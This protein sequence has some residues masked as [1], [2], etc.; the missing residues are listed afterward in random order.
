MDRLYQS[1]VDDLI[2]NG[3]VESMSKYVQHG[4][5]STLEHCEHVSYLSYKICKSLRLDYRAAARGGLLHDYFLYDWHINPPTEW[6]GY[7]HPAIALK[8]AQRD[9]SLNKKECDI[10]KKHMWPLTLTKVPKYP[11][12]F[13]VSF[14]DKYATVYEV[15]MSKKTKSLSDHLVKPV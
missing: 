13:I 11:E 9:F 12:S 3:K 15:I 7:R 2:N 5:I 8:N 14:A 4:D 10:I 6:H 1:C